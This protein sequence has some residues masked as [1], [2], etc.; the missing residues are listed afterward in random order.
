[1]DTEKNWVDWKHYDAYAQF[2]FLAE[3]VSGSFNYTFTNP[4]LYI[5]VGAGSCIN[6]AINPTTNASYKVLYT[7]SSKCFVT[8]I[9]ASGDDY[10]TST[11]ST[12]NNT[13]VALFYIGSTLTNTTLIQGKHSYDTTVSITMDNCI[14]K[15]LVG[16]S[17]ANQRTL[18]FS[19]TTAQQYVKSNVFA[20]C[21]TLYEEGSA[22]MSVYGYNNG[23]PVVAEI[24]LS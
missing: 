15:V 18:S 24:Q 4:G 21:T 10:I 13:G 16:Y 2:Q 3:S 7:A 5:Y 8:S 12:A 22:S 14:N 11:F 1:M 23:C 9:V 20:C 6:A 19:C 17:G